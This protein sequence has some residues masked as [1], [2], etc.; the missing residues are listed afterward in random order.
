MSFGF[1]FN[2]SNFEIIFSVNSF[3]FGESKI[4]VGKNK[5]HI[6]F[7]IEEKPFV[8]EIRSK[9]KIDNKFGSFIRSR[10]FVRKRFSRLRS[11]K[12]EIFNNSI[13]R[14]IR[15]KKLVVRTISFLYKK[16]DN[17]SN[18]ISVSISDFGNFRFIESM[19]KVKL[20]NMK[21]S[22]DRISFHSRV[23]IE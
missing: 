19:D 9:K 15:I 4:K 14:R 23:I 11:K 8:S 18:S 10:P 16:I 6:E 21:S 22:N 20:A 17:I 5:R 1:G 3:D 12:R 7:E 13:K 2:F